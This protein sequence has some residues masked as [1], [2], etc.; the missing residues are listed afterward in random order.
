MI[1]CTAFVCPEGLRA[2]DTVGT[3]EKKERAERACVTANPPL[4]VCCHDVKKKKKKNM[5]LVCCDSCRLKVSLKVS[6]TVK[7]TVTCM[8]GS[9]EVVLVV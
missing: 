8:S 2:P 7:Q 3:N 6:R 5:C 9:T 1:A 4:P